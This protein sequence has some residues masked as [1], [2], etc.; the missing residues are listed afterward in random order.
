MGENSLEYFSIIL[1]KIMNKRNDNILASVLLW[2][3][4][5]LIKFWPSQE[6]SNRY[7][8]KLEIIHCFMFLLIYFPTSYL[9]S[10]LVKDLFE[11]YN[12]TN[13]LYL[14]LTKNVVWYKI[15]VNTYLMMVVWIFLLDVGDC[16]PWN[17]TIEF[18][19]ID[20]KNG[21]WFWMGLVFL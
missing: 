19:Y 13:S 14:S 5:T 3:Q 12:M 4:L 1:E 18:S 9:A 15:S 7:S 10:I 6:K 17:D 8:T 2:P 20:W 11:Y 21:Y 16:L